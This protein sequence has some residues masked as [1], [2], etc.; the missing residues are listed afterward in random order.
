VHGQSHRRRSSLLLVRQCIPALTVAAI[1]LQCDCQAI[2]IPKI[3]SGISP[4]RAPVQLV[5]ISVTPEDAGNFRE[6][7]RDEDVTGPQGVGDLGPDE[8]IYYVIPCFR[9]SLMSPAR[10]GSATRALMRRA[11]AD[12]VSGRCDCSRQLH[13]IESDHRMLA[14]QFQP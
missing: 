1:V 3:A 4:P 14:V 2:N 11:T 6:A 13:G 12:V 7:L 8:V 9:A 5:G 10:R